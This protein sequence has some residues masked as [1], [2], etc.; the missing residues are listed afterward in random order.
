MTGLCRLHGHKIQVEIGVPGLYYTF[1][2]LSVFLMKRLKDGSGINNISGPR[3][4]NNLG[5]Y[6]LPVGPVGRG[7]FL[8]RRIRLS[9]ITR[10]PLGAKGKPP[11]QGGFPVWGGSPFLM[12][13]GIALARRA[14]SGQRCDYLAIAMKMA[15]SA[16]SS[17]S[18]QPI[19][20]IACGSRPA[21]WELL[22]PG[23]RIV[24]TGCSVI[25]GRSF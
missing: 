11:N 1:P 4:E 15:S 22:R 8:R 24:W 17:V 19:P 13:P 18:A 14:I 3:I 20:M 5:F 2:R 16:S 23:W 10:D 12:G 25:K 9:Y 6:H 21:S 7:V